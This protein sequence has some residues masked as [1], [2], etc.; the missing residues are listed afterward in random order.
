VGQFWIALNHGEVTFITEGDQFL[1]VGLISS[2]CSAK[3]ADAKGI[4]E[5]GVRGGGG[6]ITPCNSIASNIKL[7]I[8]KSVGIGQR[9]LVWSKNWVWCRCTALA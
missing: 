3:S 4:D 7:S 1:N 9:C 2:V 6:T 5:G 8:L